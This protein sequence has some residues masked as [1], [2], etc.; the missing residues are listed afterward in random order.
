[1]KNK[2]NLL[3]II[4]ECIACIIVILMYKY[5]FNSIQ[6]FN[7]SS[8]SYVS[9]YEKNNNSNFKISKSILY[10][11]AYANNNI[12]SSNKDDWSIEIFQY[13][14][15]AIYIKPKSDDFFVKKIWIDTLNLSTPPV[16]GK[17]NI[18][19]ENP[20]K[21]GTEFIQ[22]DYPFNESMEFE[23]VNDTNEANEMQYNTPIFFSD[24]SIPLT[25]KYVN[26]L[27]Q[28]FNL[29]N[30]YT[31]TQNGTILKNIIT[32]TS[33]INTNFSFIIHLVDNNNS[34]YKAFFNISIPLK[35]FEKDILV[36]GNILEI[37]NNMNQIFINQ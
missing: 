14:D 5:I 35:N 9:F 34:E 12:N 21:F 29:K 28:N 33:V 24:C 23:I 19:Y 22:K 2:K 37:N 1:M 4:I 16:I 20:T 13:T 18:F 17:T 11:S 36:D 25:L 31:L 3:F 8:N 10:S 15:I 26:T 27:S 6:S 30:S 7:N 32:D